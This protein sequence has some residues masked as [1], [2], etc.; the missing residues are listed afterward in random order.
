L[1]FEGSVGN[2]R[3]LVEK[4]CQRIPL[5][6]LTEIHP[7]SR[8][9]L[10]AFRS[11]ELLERPATSELPA[12]LDVPLQFIFGYRKAAVY[13]GEVHVAHSSISVP[14]KHGID[15]FRKLRAARLVDAAGVDPVIL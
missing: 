8:K 4:F 13:V 14:A 6:S 15:G 7:I 1:S 11:N 9:E 2:P 3:Y 5:I 12:S 10:N